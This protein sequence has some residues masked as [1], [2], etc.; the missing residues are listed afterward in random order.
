M[1]E[2]LTQDPSFRN[3]YECGVKEDQE[4]NSLLLGPQPRLYMAPVSQ[5]LSGVSW[6]QPLG[7]RL[8]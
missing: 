6:M 8:R 4:F 5:P 7:V 1:E 2:A 3:Q